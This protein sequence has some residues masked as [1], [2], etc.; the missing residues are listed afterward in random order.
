MQIKINTQEVLDILNRVPDQAAYAAMLAINKTAGQARSEVQ[1]EMQRVFDKPTPWVIDSLRIKYATKTN[2]TASLAYKDKNS[3]ESSRTMVEPH[4]LGG[5]RNY[6]GFEV[7]L[8]QAGY[9]PAGWNAVPGAGADLDAYGN[10]SQGQIS[11]LLNVLGTYTEAG[12]NKANSKTIT[13]LAKGNK[14]KG[15]YGFEYWVNPANPTGNTPGRH[16]PPGVYKRV[17][18]GFGT[19]LNP[20]LIFVKRAAYKQRLEFYSIVEMVTNRDIASNVKDAMDQA[21]TTALLKGQGSLL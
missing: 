20:V 10:M 9:L 11:Q 1:T 14:K 15:I 13:R 17:N 4:V 21:M 2:L 16:L 18:T 6:K 12:Y 19:S 5:P 3:V 7:R 8:M